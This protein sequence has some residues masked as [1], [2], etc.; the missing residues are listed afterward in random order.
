MSE[1]L[2]AA[3]IERRIARAILTITVARDPDGRYRIPLRAWWPA[4]A[5]PS[6]YPPEARSRIFEPDR[7][8]LDR[9]LDDLRWLNALTRQ[10]IRVVTARA[11]GRSFT[12][13]SEQLG[14]S[15]THWRRVYERA[16]TAMWWFANHAITRAHAGR[17]E[18]G[19]KNI[20]RG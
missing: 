18:P 16:I 2:T 1:K 9:Y 12:S 17:S 6:D 19:K 4:T 11:F 15:E 20:C 3:D 14:M 13:L 8:D 10:E 7:A 5:D